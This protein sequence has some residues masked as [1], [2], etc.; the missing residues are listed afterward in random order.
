MVTNR[1]GM[2]MHITAAIPR[3]LHD[4]ALFRDTPDQLTKLVTSKPDEPTNILSNKEY[5]GFREDSLVQF[6]R[7][8]QKSAQ[9]TLR[10]REN[11][12]NYNLASVRV[13]V[14]NFLADSQPSYT[15]WSVVGNSKM[16]T[17]LR[18][19]KFAVLWPISISRRG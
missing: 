7:P 14:E 13:M 8:H 5:I 17:I 6:V 16:N 4:L 18:Y 1:R 3:S 12:E 11:R 15:S 9:R 2:A 19:L 10:P